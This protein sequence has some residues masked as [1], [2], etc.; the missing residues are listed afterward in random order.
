LFDPT[1]RLGVSLPNDFVI[2][3]LGTSILP[4]IQKSLNRFG[5]KAV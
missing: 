2:E 5:F 4:K 1:I 3:R